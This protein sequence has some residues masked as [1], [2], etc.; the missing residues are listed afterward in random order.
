MQITID[1]S[2]GS[3]MPVFDTLDGASPAYSYGA[4]Q[5]GPVSGINPGLVGSVQPSAAQQAAWEESQS[6]TLNF[7]DFTPGKLFAFTTDVDDIVNFFVAGFEFAGATLD[8]VFSDGTG[9][10]FSST[11]TYVGA[12]F[13]TPIN[14]AYAIVSGNT[15]VVPVPGA[16]LLL[17]SAVGGLGGLARWRS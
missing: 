12:G 15:A 17:M 4:A 6:I 2:G 14:D 16:L 5:G 9:S 1:L 8:V 3:N 13:T 10:Q 11:G 7:T